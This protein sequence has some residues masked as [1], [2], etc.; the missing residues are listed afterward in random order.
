M[1]LAAERVK[2]V[3]VHRGREVEVHRGRE[4]SKAQIVGIQYIFLNMRETM[5]FGKLKWSSVII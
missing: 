1:K 3:E 2:K 4:L 5:R